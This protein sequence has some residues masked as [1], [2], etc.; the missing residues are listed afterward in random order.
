MFEDEA[1][2]R[3]SRTPATPNYSF[4]H[5]DSGYDKLE[6]LLQHAYARPSRREPR[7]GI[8][9]PLDKL[10]AA[11]LLC[12]VVSVPLLWISYMVLEVFLPS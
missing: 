8:A 12:A 7:R 6:P 4:R 10:I 11:I 9:L 1:T 2:M 5:P 3:R